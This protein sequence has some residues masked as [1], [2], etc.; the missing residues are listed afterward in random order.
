MPFCLF[1]CARLPSDSP[2]LEAGCNLLCGNIQRRGR[3]RK[4]EQVGH[5]EASWSRLD[6]SRST[7]GVGQ[8][9]HVAALL[10]LCKGMTKFMEQ[11]LLEVLSG[12][13]MSKGW[14]E[15]ASMELPA[16]GSA[17]W[18]WLPSVMRQMTHT[19]ERVVDAEYFDFSKALG[20]VSN[21]ILIAKFVRYAWLSR[22]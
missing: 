1:C 11:E 12:A 20:V 4:T 21:S 14:L 8:H 16:A 17:W 7:R 5:T 6:V 15:T 13:W 18:N 22:Q 10:Q 19:E 2:A 3:Q 9:H